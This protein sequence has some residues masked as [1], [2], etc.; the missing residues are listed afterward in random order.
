MRRC[1]R[2]KRLLNLHYFGV[3]N[4]NKSGKKYVCKECLAKYYEEIKVRKQMEAKMF[5]EEV[6]EIS[7]KEKGLRLMAKYLIPESELYPPGFSYN[8][9]NNN[10]SE[11][12]IN[13]YA[14]KDLNNVDFID[15]MSKNDNHLRLMTVNDDIVIMKKYQL[16]CSCRCRYFNIHTYNCSKY[17]VKLTNYLRCG[18][19]L[20]EFNNLK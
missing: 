3:D 15:E 19:C 13:N 6:Y 8:S 14:K 2:C 9:N 18:K 5:Q 10:L 16:K 7:E 12:L 4:S 11:E 20:E 1:P 17:K